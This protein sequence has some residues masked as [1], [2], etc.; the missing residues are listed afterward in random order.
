MTA[1]WMFETAVVVEFLEQMK[2]AAGVCLQERTRVT[3]DSLG[4]VMHWVMVGRPRSFVRVDLSSDFFLL[5]VKHVF[6]LIIQYLR[7]MGAFSCM[8]YCS[9]TFVYA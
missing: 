4:A 8:D 2:A 5:T 7:A 6:L 3:P 9:P 1:H